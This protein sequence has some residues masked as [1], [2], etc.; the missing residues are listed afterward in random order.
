MG[1]SFGAFLAFV[2]GVGSIEFE[3]L[4]QAAV[5]Y[6]FIFGF[7]SVLLRRFLPRVPSV[8]LKTLF[9]FVLLFICF[10][11]FGNFEGE[12]TANTEHP[13]ILLVT[14][15]TTRADR[16]H[17]VSR[18]YGGDGLEDGSFHFPIAYTTIGLTAPAHASLFT[19]LHPH[20]HRLFNNG[21]KLG[22]APT[23]AEVLREA[24]Y[25]TMAAPSV[26]HLDPAFGFG[27]GFKEFAGVEGGVRGRYRF[28]NPFRLI[29][30]F[31]SLFGAGQVTRSGSETLGKALELWKA[32][33]PD[34]PRFLWAH[35]FEPHWPYEPPSSEFL[36]SSEMQA[37]ETGPALGYQASE[38]R[39]WQVAYDG[40]L[41]YSRNLL[42]NF[43]NQIQENRSGN[44]RPL[45][46]F[47]TADH[48]EALGEHG[49]TDHGDLLYEEQ[50]R[51]PFWLKIPGVKAGENLTPVSHVDFLPSL[52]DLLNLDSPEGLP[53]RS[54][55]PAL[56]NQSL[57]EVPIYAESR[58]A[59]FDNAMCRF[60]N[61][62]LIRNLVVSS[63]IM[64]RKP[65]PSRGVPDSIAWLKPWE[66]YDL[67]RD[68]LEL[69]RMEEKP[70]P[71]ADQVSGYL[72]FFLE[73][74]GS[75][76]LDSD[77]DRLAPDVIDAMRE[78]GYF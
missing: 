11:L 66:A 22:D 65:R 8:I 19:G 10:G 52:L 34:R 56:F 4:C 54:W 58:Q 75:A 36:Q 64:K 2:E 28:L 50:I 18:S 41:L 49:A 25:F 48:G 29:R 77:R 40:E 32:A 6:A 67:M 46:I 31:F 76:P 3:L 53:G 17:A 72:E 59:A 57:P 47:F 45:W 74:R 27:I 26:V 63:E 14:L 60:A 5:F 43:V 70:P 1:F 55:A 62:K 42:A 7:F 39:S 71:P 9:S 37:W 30:P 68:P 15:D 35:L 23:L 13:D 61:V 12:T 24:G 33:P 20:Q 38:V 16:W 44:A 78:L 51:V 21:G 69:S 73:Q